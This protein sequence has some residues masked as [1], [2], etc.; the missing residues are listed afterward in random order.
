MFRFAMALAVML[1]SGCG[2][3]EQEQLQDESAGSA[4]Q[5]LRVGGGTMSGGSTSCDYV[6]CTRNCREEGLCMGCYDA[7]ESCK[8]SPS[9]CLSACCNDWCDRACSGSNSWT[10]SIQ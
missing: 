8:K 10:R 3:T 1:T 4:E 9:C 6:A 7:D 5:G 2:Y